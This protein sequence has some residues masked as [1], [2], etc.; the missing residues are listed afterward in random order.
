MRK[1]TRHNVVRQAVVLTFSVDDLL[2]AV[3]FPFS[4]G[5]R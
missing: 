2:S 5:E 1:G 4:G 3:M